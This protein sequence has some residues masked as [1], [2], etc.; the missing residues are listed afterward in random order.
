M[1]RP[2][3][4]RTD[5][6]DLITVLVSLIGFGNF[7]PPP[8]KFNR[9]R[10]GSKIPWFMLRNGPSWVEERKPRMSFLL[11][12]ADMWVDLGASNSLRHQDRA[13]TVHG[14]RG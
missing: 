6:N 2:C 7:T 1:K 4:G 13:Y 8:T 10:L 14:S 11:T 5:I 9:G 3:R 12:I